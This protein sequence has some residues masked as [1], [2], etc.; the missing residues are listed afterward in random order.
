MKIDTALCMACKLY[1]PSCHIVNGQEVIVSWVY[2]NN[3]V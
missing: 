1:L 2:M 3:L